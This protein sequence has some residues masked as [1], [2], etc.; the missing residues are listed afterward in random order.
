MRHHPPET[1]G[2]QDRAAVATARGERYELPGWLCVQL[3]K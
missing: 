2:Q 3:L 1:H